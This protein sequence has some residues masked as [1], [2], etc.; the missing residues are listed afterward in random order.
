MVNPNK[1]AWIWFLGLCAMLALVACKP[2]TSSVP[3]TESQS[4]S[5][6]GK[7]APHDHAHHKIEPPGSTT[8]SGKSIYHLTGRW[9]DHEGRTVALATL[10]G[11]TL[12][13]A[14]VYTSCQYVC[15]RITSDMLQIQRALGSTVE[16]NV[17]FVLFSFDP[18]RDKPDVLKRYKQQ[19]G[20]NDRWLLMTADDD[21]AIELAAVLGVKY[22]KDG[23]NDYSHSNIISVIDG[24]GVIRHQQIGLGQDPKESL[25]TLNELLKMR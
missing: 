10:K 18:E 1:Y 24:E 16:K 20:L 14:M 3:S 22:K 23:N 11:R 21:T 5:H 4:D 19:R 8:L 15:P 13:A 25:A 12:V 9:T 6:Q 17:T 7:S 2:K